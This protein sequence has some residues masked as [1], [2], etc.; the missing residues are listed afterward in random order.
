MQSIS[1]I[2]QYLGEA[3]EVASRYLPQ[4]KYDELMADFAVKKQ[5]EAISIMLFG[6][7]NA[8]KSSLINALTG[9]GN[10][11]VGEIPTTD[12]VNSYRWNDCILLDT[13]GVNAPIEHEE[14]TEEQI[15][16]SQLIVCVVRAGDQ[17]V[18]DVYDRMFSMLKN[19]KHIFVV[20][21]HS[22]EDAELQQLID[23]FQQVMIQFAAV[24]GVTPAMLAQ[25]N[26]I[27]VN[28]KS[29]IKA[30]S[31]GKKLLEERSGIHDLDCA[32]DAWIR[33]HNTETGF[34]DRFKHYV[35]EVVLKPVKN[36]VSSEQD[37]YPDTELSDRQYARD[38][39]TRKFLLIDG[40][41][42]N[43]VNV[44]VNLAKE[45][46]A[47]ILSSGDSK[48]VMESEIQ[49]MCNDI[50]DELVA[51]LKEELQLT[52]DNLSI[53]VDNIPVA[54]EEGGN[55]LGSAV[56]GMVLNGLKNVDQNMI[57]QGLLKLREWKI[58]K[59]KGRWE[60]TLGNWAGKAALAIQVGLALYEVYQANDEENKQNRKAQS[61]AME[62]NQAVDSVA[63]DIRAALIKQ[64]QTLI[65]DMKV[66]ALAPIEE[67]ISNLCDSKGQ[68]V[69]DLE[70]INAA[71]MEVASVVI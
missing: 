26:V 32:F 44:K 28:L 43:A 25:I 12:H 67:Q 61:A 10:A 51:E 16:K 62:F 8:G 21:N 63:N 7:Y 68:I 4:A 37:G 18:Q 53:S 34:L 33:Q 35:D 1:Q 13:P 56:E 31:E 40:K 17:D 71:R 45:K 47:G 11:V 5:E 3:L 15:R 22:H 64:F 20:L 52:I 70:V 69:S 57:K 50:S 2:E 58:P 42:T 23:K 48:A 46:I 60:K 41:M 54:G 55:A 59:I 38:D 24:H 30:R 66:A 14:V 6:S 9:D 29:A 49:Q 39:L 65:A 36:A 19:G 27:P